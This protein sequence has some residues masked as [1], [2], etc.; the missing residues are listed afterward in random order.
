M[1]PDWKYRQ[2]MI[3]AA[4]IGGVVL[5]VSLVRLLVRRLKYLRLTHTQRCAISDEMSPTDEA[6]YYITNWYPG[7]GAGDT[8]KRIPGLSSP[9][10][11]LETAAIAMKKAKSS[12]AFPDRHKEHIAHAL[13]MIVPNPFLEPPAAVASVYL[14]TRFEFYFR[15]LSGRL[16]ANGF[17]KTDKDKQEVRKLL[18]DSDLNRKRINSVA[19]AYKI[20][21]TNKDIPLVQV[22]N[23]LDTSLYPKPIKMP[24]GTTVS[25]IGDRIEYLRH[26]VAHGY[27]GDISGDANF[28]GLMTAIVFYN[29]GDSYG[30]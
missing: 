15:V 7:M 14:V 4:V 17:W 30:M 10:A 25:D 8:R 19:L 6:I 20:M 13:Q 21:K 27:W 23:D 24:D 1:I 12:D 22:C 28:Y 18:S 29:K 3:A 9:S 11:V 5:L 26:R 2:H 16:K